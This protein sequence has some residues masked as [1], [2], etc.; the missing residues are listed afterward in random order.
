MPLKSQGEVQKK[1]WTQPYCQSPMFSYY[2]ICS[3]R[4][5]SLQRANGKTKHVSFSIFK[6]FAHFALISKR[7]EQKSCARWQ[8]KYRVIQKKLFLER[9]LLVSWDFLQCVQKPKIWSPIAPEKIDFFCQF[10]SDFFGKKN[11]NMI[12]KTFDPIVKSGMY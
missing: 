9:E 6:G 3:N 12:W 7:L 8:K 10:R 5:N 2:S 4:Y 11:S 1:S